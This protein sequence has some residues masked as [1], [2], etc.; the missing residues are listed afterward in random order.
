VILAVLLLVV[1]RC[2]ASAEE[3]YVSYGKGLEAF[4]RQQWQSAVAALSDAIGEKADSRAKAKTYGMQFIDYFPYVYRGVAYYKLGDKE[5]AQA[6]LEK[7]EGEGVVG[8]AREDENAPGLLREYLD[9]VRKKSIPAAPQPDARYAEGMRLYN[10]KEYAAALTQLGGVPSTAKEYRDAQKYIGLAQTELKKAEAVTTARDRKNRIDNAFAAGVKAFNNNA[11]DQAE[12]EFTT[13]LGLDNSRADAQR[14]LARIRSQRQKIAAADKPTREQTKIPIRESATEPTKAAVDTSSNAV[15]RAALL[16]YAEGKVG[17]AKVKFEEIRKNEPG[18]ADAANYLRSIEETTQKT[19]N[20]IAAFFEGEYQ[21]AID[22][23]NE[24]AKRE[25]DN[26][27]LYAFLACSYAARF[28]LAGE[29]DT[30]LR[31]N[32]LAAYGKVKNVD[33]GYTLDRKLISP[34]IVSV[35][36]AP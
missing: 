7:A 12:T 25:T 20:G 22:Q 35:L 28:L 11:L 27:H 18:N 30:G 8:D 15:L 36:G 2:S 21:Q 26:P 17:R 5:K 3:W 19:R 31:D 24:S 1:L 14:Y 16:L 33:A 32:A 9:L 23:L 4:R 29:E 10:R 34:R 6:D 13:V